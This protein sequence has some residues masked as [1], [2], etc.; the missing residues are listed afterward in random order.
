MIPYKWIMLAVSLLLVSLTLCL[1]ADAAAIYLKDADSPLVGYIKSRSA[2][3]ILMIV[4]VDD[5]T[6]ERLIPLQQIVDVLETV[7]PKRLAKL[8][9]ADV[10]QYRDYAE[11]LMVKQI[12]PEARETAIRLFLIS[13]FYGDAQLQRSG[14]RSLVRLSRNDQ[15]RQQFMALAWRYGAI[16]SSQLRGN[17]NGGAGDTSVGGA[18]L[19]GPV[20]LTLDQRETL[21]DLI[22]S[23]RSNMVRRARN[24][25]QRDEV[26]AMFVDNDLGMTHKKFVE[27]LSREP[28]NDDI[29]SL[30]ELELRVMAIETAFSTKE[31]SGLK[32]SDLATK[33]NTRPVKSPTIETVTE[34]NPRQCYFVDGKWTESR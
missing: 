32:W 25:A 33:E 11:E 30:V 26:K 21:S 34:F 14:L 19:R 24:L 17:A 27:L 1:N 10:S 7:D 28:T 2:T 20:M 8:D 29:A 18:G 15:E 31:I 4:D 13:V 23:S 16:E 3:H 6:E 9:P 12:D 5:Q 22:R